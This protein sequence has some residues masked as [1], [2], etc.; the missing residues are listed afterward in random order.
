V[1]EHVS[2]IEDRSAIIEACSRLAWHVDHREWEL[3]KEVFADEVLLDYTSL[4]G[5]EP[6]TVT[7]EQIAAGWAR[8]LGGYDATHH[9]ITNHLVTVHADA[10]VCT[11]S[12]Q[13]VHRLANLFGSPLWT[14]GGTYRFTLTRTEGRWRINGMTLTVVWAEGN[15]DLTTLATTQ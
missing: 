4:N 11:A 7:P 12:F 1:E 2:D 8:G 5:G 13:A 3:L 14:L 9:L 15:K 10:A 6:A